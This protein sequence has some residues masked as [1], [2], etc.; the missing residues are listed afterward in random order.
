MQAIARE[1]R[2]NKSLVT[3]WLAAGQPERKRFEVGTGWAKSPRISRIIGGEHHQA[4]PATVR[5][6]QTTSVMN[7]KALTRALETRSHWSFM[8]DNHTKGFSKVGCGPGSFSGG[9]Q[10][11]PQIHKDSASCW[12]PGIH[13]DV[14]GRESNSELIVDSPF[15]FAFCRNGCKY[16]GKTQQSFPWRTALGQRQRLKNVFCIYLKQ[17][18]GIRWKISVCTCSDLRPTNLH[19]IPISCVHW[20]KCE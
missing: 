5:Y 2:A 7:R 4:L 13:T 9:R 16:G 8:F 1:R 12:E 3:A 15:N 14:M 11:W 17:M 20:R 18:N 19:L 10:P 6:F